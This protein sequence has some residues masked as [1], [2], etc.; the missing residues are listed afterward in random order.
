MRCSGS[1]P[2]VVE[3]APGSRGGRPPWRVKLVGELFFPPHSVAAHHAHAANRPIDKLAEGGKVD[4]D[5]L[6]F[7]SCAVDAQVAAVGSQC[8][9][10]TGLTGV[11][12]AQCPGPPIYFQGLK[13]TESRKSS[14]V[15]H[16][17]RFHSRLMP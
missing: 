4:G 1:R 17:Y 14:E 12:A 3:P 15:F 9:A 7:P 2:V 5:K 16:Y 8:Q 6:P 11:D 10:P 13:N